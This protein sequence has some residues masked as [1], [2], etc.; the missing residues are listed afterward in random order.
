MQNLKDTYEQADIHK[1][2]AS[3][4]RSGRDSKF[5]DLVMRRVMSILQPKKDAHFLDAGCGTGEHTSRICDHGYK[6]TSVDISE[7]ALQTARASEPRATFSCQGLESLSFED[8]TF[9]NVHCR[10]VLMH[11]PRMQD[12][13]KELVR[14]LK[15]GGSIALLDN[16]SLSLELY[17]V[18]FIRLFRKGDSEMKVTESGIEFWS[19]ENGHPFVVRYPHIKYMRRLLNEL[20]VDVKTAATFEFLDLARFPGSVRPIVSTLNRIG[21]ALRFPGIISHG[22]LLSGTK[23][24]S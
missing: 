12:S 20:S 4:Y 23:R 13:I 24:Q 19:E 9:D 15:P 14:V 3:I 22:V 18:R 11:I 1:N 21:L 6:C 7:V 10:G 16:N 8:A 2:W 5:N 17:L